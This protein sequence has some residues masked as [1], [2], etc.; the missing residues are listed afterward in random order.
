VGRDLV[1]DPR[2]TDEAVEAAVDVLDD[3]GHNA[4][5]CTPGPD[6][7]VTTRAALE[8]A[9]PHLAPQPVPTAGDILQALTEV[10]ESG[11]MGG[12]WPTLGTD[13]VLALINGSA[14]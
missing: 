6:L 5:H 13:A 11:A 10:Y 12:E 4:L 1:T 14:K 2:I 8:A 9:L 3:D 7:Y